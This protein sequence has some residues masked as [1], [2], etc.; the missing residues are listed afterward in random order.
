MRVKCLAQEHNPV[1]RPGLKPGPFDLESSALT[2]RPPHL[3]HYTKVLTGNDQCQREKP[4]AFRGRRET[5][6]YA[7]MHR[8]AKCLQINIWLAKV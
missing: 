4:I 7:V 1:P 6:I 3:P 2:I 5:V 8:E